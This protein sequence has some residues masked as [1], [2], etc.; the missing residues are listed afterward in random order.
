MDVVGRLHAAGCVFAEREAELLRAAGGDLDALVAR[1][2]AGERLED[3]LGWA[4]FRGRR[5]AVAPGV[6]VPRHRTG[7]LVDL[8]VAHARPGDRALDLCCGTGALI[9][10]VTDR[11]PSLRVHA[12]DLL[13]P[14]TD[15]ARRNLPGATVVT[16]DLFSALPAGLRFDLV[17]ANVPY[18]PS[19]EVAHLPAEMR[20]HEDLRTLD[21]GPDGL[22]VLRRV[23]AEVGSWLSPRG[24][25]FT[26]LDEEQTPAAVECARACGLVPEVFVADEEEDDGSR[27]FSVRLP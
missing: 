22:D 9:G 7:A 16:G 1:R 6:F 4:L 19:R 26:E 12:T 17:V 20:E 13:P 5:Y 21:G 18:V 10:A 3:V 11:V 2:V 27:V 8:A 24:R 14:A 25:A 23:L 15:C